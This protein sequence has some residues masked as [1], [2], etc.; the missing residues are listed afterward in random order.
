MRHIAG[1]CFRQGN[2]SPDQIYGLAK[3]TWITQSY[4]ETH[5]SYIRSTKIPALEHIFATNFGGGSLSEIAEWIAV[6]TGD[7]EL[8]GLIESHTGFTNL[9]PAYRNQARKWCHANYVHI[10]PIVQ[11]AWLLKNDEDG[12]DL[13]RRMAQLP[14]IPNGESAVGFTDAS[15]ILTPLCFALDERLRFPV[16][17]KDAGVDQLLKHLGHSSSTLEDKYL[18]LVRMYNDFPGV[19][20]DAAVLDQSPRSL[21]K[22]LAQTGT[23]EESLGEANIDAASEQLKSVALPLK[24]EQDVAAVQ[25]QREFTQRR[26]HNMMTNQVRSL[27]GKHFVVEEGRTPNALFDVKIRDYDGWGNDLLVEAKSTVEPGAIRM[28]IGQLFDYWYVEHGRLDSPHLALLL[29]NRPSA[30]VAGLLDALDIGVLWLEGKR[31]NTLNDWLSVLA[32]RVP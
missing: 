17:N 9:Y 26:I 7:T 10:L 24:D 20:E 8:K 23:S 4:D 11:K 3:L 16:I 27:L 18:G 1:W 32:T 13:I 2:P 30:T 5:E 19:L 31:L 21:V 15:T 22:L 29:P 28:A 12:L 6:L 14:R 25:R